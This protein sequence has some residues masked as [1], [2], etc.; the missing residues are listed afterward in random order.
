MGLHTCIADLV[1]ELEVFWTLLWSL[2]FSCDA[3]FEG[4]FVLFP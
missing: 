1:M 3:E 4:G 2:R